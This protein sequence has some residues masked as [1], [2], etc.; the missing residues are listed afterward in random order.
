MQAVPA[1]QDCERV[2][3]NHYESWKKL[4]SDAEASPRS[5]VEVVVLGR[6]ISSW[7]KAKAGADAS[8]WAYQCIPDTV[9]PRG[10]KAR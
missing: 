4:A 2:S 6:M 8:S 7:T 1:Y 9:D 10:P 3:A 5:A